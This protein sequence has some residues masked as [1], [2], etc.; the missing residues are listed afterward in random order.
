MIIKIIIQ[1]EK[2]SISLPI[3]TVWFH[4]HKIL[5]NANY[6]LVPETGQWLPRDGY[7]ERAW[8]EQKRE[9]EKS[10]KEQKT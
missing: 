5:R 4:L 3:Y 7:G 2:L 1:S 9:H 10:R 8:E 6:Y